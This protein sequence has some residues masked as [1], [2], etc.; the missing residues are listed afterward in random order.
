MA[1]DK[2]DARDLFLIYA[3]A[4]TIA[5]WAMAMSGCG[6]V[7]EV[8]NDSHS[9]TT[10]TDDG[11]GNDG[12]IGRDDARVS[13]ELDS[14]DDAA[15]IDAATTGDR[16]E[17]SGAE[18]APACGVTTVCHACAAG[19]RVACAHTIVNKPWVCC[20]GAGSLACDDTLCGAF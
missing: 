14:G 9:D 11:G 8:R 5:L 3:I 17:D 12:G 2:R 1:F 15:R 13:D 7:T 19:V 10:T 18:V 16:G 20:D 4:V 6:T